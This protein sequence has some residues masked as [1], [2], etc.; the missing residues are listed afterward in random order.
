MA[1]F[2]AKISQ[3]MQLFGSRRD[4]EKFRSRLPNPEFLKSRD[5]RN[6]SS[7]TISFEMQ[8]SDKAESAIKGLY[9]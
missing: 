8:A 9:A 3:I 4:P 6:A 7:N 5:L 1:L 2:K